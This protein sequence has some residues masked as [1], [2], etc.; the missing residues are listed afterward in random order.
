MGFPYQILKKKKGELFEKKYL[1]Y[2]ERKKYI[3]IALFDYN[4]WIDA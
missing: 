1:L 2:K 4:I 3:V